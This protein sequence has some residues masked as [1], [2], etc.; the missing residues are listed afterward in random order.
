MHEEETSGRVVTEEQ[1]VLSS[2]ERLELRRKRAL[3]SIEEAR[4]RVESELRGE[5]IPDASRMREEIQDAKSE[6]TSGL[7]VLEAMVQQQPDWVE[8][9][10]S[11]RQELDFQQHRLLQLLEL[12]QRQQQQ[13]RIQVAKNSIV[14]AK[15]WAILRRGLLGFKRG[16]CKHK[17]GLAGGFTECSACGVKRD[18]ACTH[19]FGFAG[20]FAACPMCKEG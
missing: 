2:L 5:K 19:S 18:K 10:A 9:I 1:Q 14:E 13:Q 6:V 15:P 4:L 11:T 8:D 7:A 20:G 12:Q 17:F 3:L 16:L